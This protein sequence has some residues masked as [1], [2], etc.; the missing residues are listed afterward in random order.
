MSSK[1]SNEKPSEEEAK[2]KKQLYLRKYIKTGKKRKPGS[3][4]GDSSDEKDME[5]GKGLVQK[6]KH[7]DEK[8]DVSY[9]LSKPF[10]RTRDDEDLNKSQR[11][12]N[13]WGDPLLQLQKQ[14][15][16][17]KKKA[18]TEGKN[19]STSESKQSETLSVEKE[20]PKEKQKSRAPRPMYKGRPWNNRFGIR[21]GYRWDGLE[22][23]TGW[24]VKLIQASIQRKVTQQ[25]AYSWSSE[26]M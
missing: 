14:K 25:A 19:D 1:N 13:R 8:V 3:S 18:S 4:F 15:E 2:K 5:W 21:P 24:E 7:Q 20:K 26:D 10:A 11:D 16:L 23:G 6:K 9:E 12:E 22:R 17:K